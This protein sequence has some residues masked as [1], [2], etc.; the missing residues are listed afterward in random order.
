[1]AT[2]KKAER[3]EQI[4]NIGLARINLEGATKVAGGT[5]LIETEI[6]GR[7]VEI[8]VTAKSEKFTQDDLDAL[9]QERAIIEQGKADRKAQAEAKKKKDAEKRAKAKEAE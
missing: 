4:R 3:D 5:Y 7:F 6:D 2:I 9:L 8:K 1:M